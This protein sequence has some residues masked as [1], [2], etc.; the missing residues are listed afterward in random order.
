ME[1]NQSWVKEKKGLNGDLVISHFKCLWEVEKDK[2]KEVPVTM[3]FGYMEI[4]NNL[5]RKPFSKV[6]GTEALVQR[7]ED[8]M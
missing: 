2:T 7:I 6:V 1:E 5:D 3:R 8:R 4:V